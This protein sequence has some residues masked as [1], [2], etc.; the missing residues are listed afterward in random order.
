ML[1]VRRSDA[2]VLLI[3][4]A[5]FSLW[6]KKGAQES[7]PLTP[8]DRCFRLHIAPSLLIQSIQ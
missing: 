4:P 2:L 3:P 7:L 5:P 6:R 1:H 8:R